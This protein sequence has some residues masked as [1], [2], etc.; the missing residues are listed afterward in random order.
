[1]QPADLLESKKLIPDLATWVQCFCLYAAVF[2]KHSPER[3]GGPLA[4]MTLIAR[5]SAK[6]RWPNW[7]VYDQNFRQEAAETGRTLW[8]KVDPS[9][10]TQCFTN[11]TL[12]TLESW[13]RRCHSV[14]HVSDACPLKPA[15]G[16]SS[17]P[18]VSKKLLP[19]HA[20][21]KRALP[22]SIQETCKHFNNY[23]GDC[24]FGESCIYLH[25]CDNCGEHSHPCS[26][27]PKPQKKRAT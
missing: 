25:R 17:V 22:H 24:R 15:S 8:G 12:N 16:P 18:Q 4:Y 14:D 7:V 11:A 19:M 20:S 1:M 3:V 21:R 27:C 23:D 9:I 10:Y 6:Y 13:C 2:I 26:R 5:C